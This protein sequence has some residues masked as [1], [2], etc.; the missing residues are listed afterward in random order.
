MNIESE[1]VKALAD[2]IV[3][4][5]GNLIYENNKSYVSNRQYT[6]SINASQVKG[7]G[8]MAVNAVS[9][10][11][12]SLSVGTALIDNL[13]ADYAEFINLVADTA[14]IGNISVDHARADI[15]EINNAAI[16]NATIRAAQISISSTDTAFIREGIGGKYYIDN[17]AVTDANIVSLAAGT[18]MLND[19]SGNLVTLV[20]DE[21]GNIHAEAVEYDGD[22]IIVD[23]S[24]SGGKIVGSSI[25]TRELNV[26][27]IFAQS[28][29]VAKLIA[30]HIDTISLFANEGFISSLTTSIIQSPTIG[31][32]LDISSNSSI[33]LTNDRISLMITT[34]SSQAGITLTENMLRAVSDRIIFEVNNKD[35][36]DNSYIKS[37][38]DQTAEQIVMKITNEIEGTPSRYPLDIDADGAFWLNEYDNNY[39]M[40]CFVED[41]SVPDFAY[42]DNGMLLYKAKD[43]AFVTFD[44]TVDNL[45]NLYVE[46]VDPYKFCS[47]T[48]NGNFILWKNMYFEVDVNFPEI[49]YDDN[50]MLLYRAKDGAEVTFEMQINESSNLNIEIKDPYDYCT[51][52]ADGGLVLWKGIYKRLSIAQQTI[53][54]MS[55]II[56]SGDSKASM[57]MT[58]ES[59]TAIANRISLSAE[60]IDMWANQV[61]VHTMKTAVRVDDAGV[62]VGKIDTDNE[63]LIDE[64]SVNIM[65]GE[66][67]YSRFAANYVQFGN[68][69]MYKSSDGGLVFKKI[70]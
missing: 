24:L 67:R 30:D 56:E 16:D 41:D 38:I 5:Y 52:S 35:T 22:Q 9:M 46:M 28:A 29:I 54:R 58:P 3:K 21:E 19:T 37:L 43:T 62:H 61:T 25:T 20:V 55:W 69:R 59:I 39:Y 44:M 4:A 31:T 6:G 13:F 18:I 51:I 26:D 63:V 34:D 10:A 7:L 66:Q 40:S 49:A 65:Q 32:D 27:E 33:E 45:D 60:L 17:L 12:E 15:A 68:Y 2:S 48:S 53:N 23:D 42:D 14:Y 70:D 50:G 36:I 11:L 64:E 1:A 47:I 57:V 8:S